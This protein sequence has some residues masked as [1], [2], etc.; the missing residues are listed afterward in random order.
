[1]RLSIVIPALN[2]AD[3]ISTTLAPLQAMRS[4][5][6][7]II[8][9]DGGSID[10]TKQLAA[11]LVDRVI[12]NERGRAK[13]MN[14]GANAARGEALF[15]LHADSTAPNDADQL[16]LRGLQSTSRVWGRFD[17]SITGQHFFL[18]VVAW[19]M[20]LRSRWTGIATG[21][22]G[23]FMTAD[24]FT[25]AGGFADIPLMEDVAMCVVL[26]RISPPLCLKQKITTS[27]RRWEKHGVWRTIFL[28]WRI[29]LAYFLG[30]DPVALHRAYHAAK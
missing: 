18:P 28:M 24:A 8:L 4:R 11:L 30:A 21:D 3:H 19:C 14:A 5:G 13:Q 16:I 2:E 20:N 7:E 17:V 22:Q 15:F 23:L 1:M 6:V 25:A 10:A 12:D 26:K 29:R 9:V 27:G